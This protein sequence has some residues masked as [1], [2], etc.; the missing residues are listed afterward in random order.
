MSSFF[1]NV[2]SL[3]SDMVD[4]VNLQKELV[5]V[6]ITEKST[7]LISKVLT[8]A[9]LSILGIFTLLLLSIGVAFSLN[10]L[11]TNSYAGFFIV[12]GIY[13]IIGVIF[14]FARE[15][16]ITDKIAD[17]TTNILIDDEK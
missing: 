11:F 6:Q 3:P 15:S 10:E 4:Y 8:Y 14:Y 7:N 16:L 9:I 17:L 12:A 5:K 2:A 13:G 1:N